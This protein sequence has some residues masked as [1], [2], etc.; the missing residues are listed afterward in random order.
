MVF[1]LALFWFDQPNGRGLV[2]DS[3]LTLMRWA[4]WSAWIQGLGLGSG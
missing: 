3:G 2:H 1:V 4:P